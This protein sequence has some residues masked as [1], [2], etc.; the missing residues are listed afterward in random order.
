MATW[1]Q[2]RIR[3]RFSAFEVD[4]TSRVL[5]KRG[6]PVN[7]QEKPFLIL[8][9]LIEHPGEVITREELHKR[10]WP[11]GTFVDFDKG[12]NTAVKKLRL[13]LGD[14]AGT[15][16]FIET[17]PRKGYRFVAPV[18]A[19]PPAKADRPLASNAGPAIDL[20]RHFQIVP[21]HPIPLQ[22]T[23][24]RRIFPPQ[25]SHLLAY[26]LVAAL[27]SV[28]VTVCLF[29]YVRFR[30][31]Q[32]VSVQDMR[33]SRITT[34][35][36]I[37]EL[38]I[39]PD[40]R[41]L[42]Y[43]QRN[44]LM[45]SLWT[46]EI[47]TGDELQLLAPNTVNFTGI[48][49]SPDGHS[50]YFIRSESTNPVFGYLCRMQVIGGSVQELIRDADSPIS[51]SPDGHEFVFTRGYPNHNITEVRIANADGTNDHL[52]LSISGHQVYEAGATWSPKNDVV[53]VPIHIIG[54][55]SAFVLYMIS[56]RDAHARKFLFS[57]GAIGR[58]LWS[59]SGNELVVTLEDVSSHRGQLWSV[60]YPDARQHRLTNDLSD[61]S[62]AIDVSK[63]W[64]KLA[65]IVSTGV[66]N[67]WVVRTGDQSHAVQLTS[68]E[69]DIFLVSQLQSGSLLAAGDE[70]WMTDPNVT[71][72]RKFSDTRDVQWIEPC[73]RSVVVVA[74]KEGNSILIRLSVD[75]G[76][77]GVA[78]A[79]GD[80]G[81]PT[82]AADGKQIFYMNFAHPER[83]HRISIDGGVPEDVADVLGDT[84]FGNLTLS[85]DGKFLA[86]PYQQYSPPVVAVAVIPSSGG[87]PIGTFRVPGFIG[88]LRWAPHGQALQYLMTENSATNVWEQPLNGGPPRQITSFAAGK[89]F[90]F[91]WAQDGKRMFMTRGETTRDVVLIENSQ[92]H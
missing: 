2:E 58:A 83:I 87:P 23:D 59:K 64:S 9:M 92:S 14:S 66:S 37:R 44:G 89:I 6:A 29:W 76:S 82:C 53:A 52:L 10:L 16:V 90:D 67:L 34:N 86:Y 38:A 78:L 21:G 32:T 12:L 68:G 36:N 56:L 17:L 55:Q 33:I 20:Q 43:A 8:T 71:S 15:P 48:T 41:M 27:L 79:S 3:L 46:R 70:L 61:Y 51:F 49:F 50:V 74:N 77:K 39:S 65:T 7:L 54:Q 80:L 24:D 84:L 91:S 11:D 25:K 62:S 19:E 88:R 75:D 40:G 30:P 28:S 81:A 42:I 72:R 4:L 1:P 47:V 73:G 57:Q 60:S 5:Y 45:Q 18:F 13:A 31:G 22:S 26:V 63:D 35:G 85:P 69:P